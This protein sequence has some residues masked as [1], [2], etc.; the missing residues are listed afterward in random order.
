MEP[1]IHAN[2]SRDLDDDDHVR[3]GVM[4]ERHLAYRH[5]PLGEDAA[6][7]ST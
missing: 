1:H 4:G 3:A 7:R 5:G 2:R 6:A